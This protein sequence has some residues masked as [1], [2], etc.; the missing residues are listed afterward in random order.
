M[1]AEPGAAGPRGGALIL[2]ARWARGAA[3]RRLGSAPGPLALSALGSLGLRKGALRGVLSLRAGAPHVPAGRT[4]RP[5]S[6]AHR[7]AAAAVAHAG[8]RARGSAWPGLPP[9]TRAGGGGRGAPET[10]GSA[11]APLPRIQGP[12]FLLSLRGSRATGGG[13]RRGPT[14][15]P[16]RGR[17]SPGRGPEGPARRGAGP[18]TR[19]R[20]ALL[21]APR[22]RGPGWSRG[23]AHARRGRPQLHE[24]EGRFHLLMP[25]G[26]GLRGLGWV[27]PGRL[28][29]SGPTDAKVGSG[30]RA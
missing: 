29:T 27:P 12:G 30:G 4:V 22:G 5:G 16:R 19:E 18:G 3:G 2:S 10:G 21:R 25:L 14:A 8:S 11:S 9:S 1:P 26:H 6:P 13:W 20:A 17:A 15:R 7:G 24:E 23:G 28:Q